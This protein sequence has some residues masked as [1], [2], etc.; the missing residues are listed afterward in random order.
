MQRRKD[1]GEKKD[2]NNDYCGAKKRMQAVTFPER[3][4]CCSPHLLSC[5]VSG[6]FNFY[7]SLKKISVVVY[8]LIIRI[9]YMIKVEFMCYKLF[10]IN[11]SF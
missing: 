1:H 2:L 5:Q 3:T 7:N 6:L 10:H 9:T 8:G 11:C 4:G